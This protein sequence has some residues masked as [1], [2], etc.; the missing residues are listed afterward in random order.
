MQNAKLNRR[1][2]LQR[3]AVL[4]ATAVAG[5]T[6]IAACNREGGGGGGGLSC[7]D[8]TGLTPADIA[9]RTSMNYV[10]QT[11]NPEQPCRTCALYQ[12]A[13]EGACGGCTLVKGPIHPEG[14]CTAWV[15]AG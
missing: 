5:S 15:A 1:D 4:G 9:T 3:A 12:P 10:D 6:F 13:A 7:M 8:T 11:T 14:W 2:F